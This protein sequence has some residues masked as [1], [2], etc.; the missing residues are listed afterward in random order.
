MSIPA[1]PVSLV[2]YAFQIGLLT[3]TMDV[4]LLKKVMK[5]PNGYLLPSHGLGEILKKLRR[6]KYLIAS[7]ARARNKPFTLSDDGLKAARELLKSWT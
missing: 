1:A 3:D 7:Q 5:D 2:T 6:K 4:S